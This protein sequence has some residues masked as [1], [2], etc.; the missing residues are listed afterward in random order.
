MRFT[1]YV[2]RRDLR[3]LYA[4]ACALLF[5]SLYEGFGLSVLEAMI[6]GCPVVTSGISSLPE[7]C[8]EAGVYAAPLDRDDIREKS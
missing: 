3:R 7:V 2:D 1:G 4:G 6:M 8:G 5:P